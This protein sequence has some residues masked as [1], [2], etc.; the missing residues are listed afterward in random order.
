V[1]SIHLSDFIQNEKKKLESLLSSELKIKKRVSNNTFSSF[2]SI[3]C[4]K[5]YLIN[6]NFLEEENE[7]KKFLRKIKNIFELNKILSTQKTIE[8]LK[9]IIFEDEQLKALDFVQFQFS[10][11]EDV[12][13]NNE[14]F[15][16]I[17]NY[18]LNKND[19]SK[20]DNIILKLLLTN[21]K[22]I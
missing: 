4:Q 21:E 13:I 18:F 11:C 20:I 1:N 8:L 7:Y 14:D 2:M 6:K 9:K 10:H 5:K 19:F 16:M 22:Q 12:L 3:F 15:I 17:K